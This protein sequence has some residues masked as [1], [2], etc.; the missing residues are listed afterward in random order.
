MGANSEDRREVEV[1]ADSRSALGLELIWSDEATR[2]GD[3]RGCGGISATLA[4]RLI[5]E[6]PIS[7]F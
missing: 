2:E 3:L 4:V 6:E 5:L 7:G 1:K